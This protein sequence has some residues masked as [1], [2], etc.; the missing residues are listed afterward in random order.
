VIDARAEFCDRLHFATVVTNLVEEWTTASPAHTV[1]GMEQHVIGLVLTDHKVPVR[2]V[3]PVVVEMVN[4]GARWKRF[5]KGALC[6]N[7][8][9]A[10]ALGI[11]NDVAFRSG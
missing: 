1:K 2:V 4:N 7:D 3:R 9:L 10:F 11:C 5:P 8:V 6:D